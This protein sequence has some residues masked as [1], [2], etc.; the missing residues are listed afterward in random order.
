MDS[1]LVSIRFGGLFFEVV[2][3]EGGV[4]AGDIGGNSSLSVSNGARFFWA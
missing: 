2:V 3:S 4:G 1:D